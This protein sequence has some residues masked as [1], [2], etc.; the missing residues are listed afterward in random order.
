MRTSWISAWLWFVALLL[1]ACTLTSSDGSTRAELGRDAGDPL[2]PADGPGIGPASDG[3]G[4]TDC[5]TPDAGPCCGGPPDGGWWGGPDG[6]WGVH[7]AGPCCGGWPDAGG[8][9]GRD[10]GRADA[11]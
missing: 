3:G 7:D 9:P 10:A 5:G 8:W 1:P 2:P 11:S 6:G 4:P